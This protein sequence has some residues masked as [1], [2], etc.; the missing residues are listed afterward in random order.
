MNQQSEMFACLTKKGTKTQVVLFLLTDMFALTFPGNFG[1]T[2]FP[3]CLLYLAGL[4]FKDAPMK[5]IGDWGVPTEIP[6]RST[7]V[8]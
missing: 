4:N 2:D 6:T 3:Y 7:Q 1:V 8:N 5:G